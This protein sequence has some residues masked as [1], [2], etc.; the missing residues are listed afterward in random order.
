MSKILV[1]SVHPDD[2]TL[3]C[4]GT[5][6]KLKS[7]GNEINWCIV[8][9]M[10][11]D[12]GYSKEAIVQREKE[13]QRVGERYGFGRV[14]TLGLPAAGL[15]TLDMKEIVAPMSDV[16]NAIEPDTLILPFKWDV[17]SDHRVT[18][19]A[20]WSCAKPFRAPFIKT[21]LMMETLSETEMAP[22]IGGNWFVPNYYVDISLF[23]EQKIDMMKYYESEIKPSPFPRSEENIK[24]LAHFRGASVGC[25]YAEAFMILREIR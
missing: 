24:A 20:A 15:D 22:P 1:I 5:L 9:R 16:I 18:F 6:L 21:V 14:E 2:E 7:Q 10:E 11:R 8:T 3:G 13:I 25:T 17:H 12:S 23:L 19:N 4:G